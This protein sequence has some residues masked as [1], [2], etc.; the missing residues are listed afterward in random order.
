ME[1]NKSIYGNRVDKIMEGELIIV[2]FISLIGMIIVLQLR[3]RAYFKKANFKLQT[4][5]VK[6][7]NRIKLKKLEREMGITS[8]KKEIAPISDSGAIGALLPLLSNLE[9]EQLGSIVSA[10]TGG[11]GEG[12][13]EGLTGIIMDFAEKNPEMVKGLIEGFVAKKGEKGQI[14]VLVTLQ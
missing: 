7:E 12:E 13:P 14:L 1:C 8:P 9:P 10:L 4:D 6:A 11:I 2:S 5:N 3:D